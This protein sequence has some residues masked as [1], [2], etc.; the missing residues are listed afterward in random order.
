MATYIGRVFDGVAAGKSKAAFSDW[1]V[2]GPAV[3]PRVPGRSDFGT[4]WDR[5]LP[6]RG[7]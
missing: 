2:G 4:R 5:E 7:W 3:E 6:P 1:Q